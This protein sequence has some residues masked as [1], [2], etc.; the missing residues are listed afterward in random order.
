M[1]G[2]LSRLTTAL[3]KAAKA[4]VVTKRLPI[5]LTEFGI[6]ST[7]DPIY[8]VSLQRQAEYRSYSE[9]LAFDNPRVKAFSQ[10]LLTDDAVDAAGPGTKYG[11]F[12]SGL[13]TSTGKAKPSLDGFRLPLVAKRTGTSTKV[14]LWGLVRPAKGVTK[15]VVQQ[16]SSHS[17][18][19]TT[20]KTVTT[21]ARGAW[22]SSAT[23]GGA[24][25]EWRVTW[26]D[27]TGKQ[28]TGPATRSMG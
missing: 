5:Y 16:R 9:R 10:Y 3:D 27:A 4:G 25:R 7:P 17:G 12:E 2:V 1:I 24:A 13:R 8:G 23:R 11:G 14:A 21:N 19:F 6:Q 20:L 26:T 28:W 22:T 18:T 15:V